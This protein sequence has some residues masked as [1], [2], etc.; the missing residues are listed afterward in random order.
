MSMALCPQCRKQATPKCTREAG[1]YCRNCCDC[2]GHK[3]RMMMRGY[4]S[5]VSKMR[6]CLSNKVRRAIRRTYRALKHTVHVPSMTKPERVKW[7]KE[8]E[9][10]YMKRRDAEDFDDDTGDYNVFTEGPLKG[11]NLS[12]YY[13]DY[14]RVSL[15]R[16]RAAKIRCRWSRD[17]RAEWMKKRSPAETLD[18][19]EAG[20]DDLEPPSSDAG[21]GQDPLWDLYTLEEE[22]DN[23]SSS[24]GEHEHQQHGDH[25]SSGPSWWRNSADWSAHSGAA[26]SNDWSWSW[27]SGW[28][29]LS[30]EW[31]PASKSAAGESDT[32]PE[33]V[34][35]TCRT[36]PVAP[37]P[38]LA[39]DTDIVAY[40]AKLEELQLGPAPRDAVYPVSLTAPLAGSPYT[41]LEKQG[42][43]VWD[44][45]A[46]K[47][48]PH[49]RRLL[50]KNP[51]ECVKGQIPAVWKKWGWDLMR[52]QPGKLTSFEQVTAE[53]LSWMALR[54]SLSNR[55]DSMLVRENLKVIHID[56]WDLP[57]SWLQFTMKNRPQP[58][59]H[60]LP[61]TRRFG[62]HGTS[63]YCISRIF[64]ND[65]LHTGMAKLTIDGKELRGIYYHSAERAHLCQQTYMH[66]MG[67]GGG[68]YVAPL[69]VLDSEIQCTS[70]D[71]M[72]VKSVAKRKGPSMTQYITYEGQHQ[73]DGLI[74]HVIHASQMLKMPKA[75]V[76][77]AEPG[78]LPTLELDPKETWEKIQERSRS[79]AS[80]PPG[81]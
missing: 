13:L 50:G 55:F 23:S 80:V 67:F 75:A 79:L 18:D 33:S 53:V 51:V 20:L 4:R 65:G 76:V 30:S 22:S 34:W 11:L 77:N 59:M 19:K 17:T 5:D 31:E 32:V 39:S 40:L 9:D 24:S 2:E 46:D 14:G 68:W 66:Y 16:W 74:L 6:D 60:T 38:G 15:L 26:G 61:S 57:G 12:I 7:K 42:R 25:G 58:H 48:E 62:Y 56:M 41:P 44:H 1:P 73:V 49:I 10:F 27:H 37:P 78:W 52:M 36:T 45:M 54:P 64:E 8:I 69:V 70:P 29:R 28:D 63:M 72:P 21:S 47:S 43:F 3:P 71:G 35:R 81:T